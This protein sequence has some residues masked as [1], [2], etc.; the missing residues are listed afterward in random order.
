MGLKEYGPGK[1]SMLFFAAAIALALLVL[2]LLVTS[3]GAAFVAA[4]PP[5]MRHIP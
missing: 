2:A 3:Q 4:F 1:A 5:E